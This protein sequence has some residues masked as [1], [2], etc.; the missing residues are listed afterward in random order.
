[1]QNYVQPGLPRSMHCMLWS[2]CT[3]P[4]KAEFSHD[5]PVALCSEESLPGHKGGQ[6]GA[7]PKAWHSRSQDADSIAA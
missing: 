4:R 2:Q 7:T 3:W 5:V 6:D 1:M